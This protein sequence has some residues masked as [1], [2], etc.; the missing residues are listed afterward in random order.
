MKTITM[1]KHV[2]IRLNK[3][4]DDILRLHVRRRGDVRNLIVRAVENTDYLRLEVKSR[5][6]GRTK[7]TEQEYRDTSIMFSLPVFQKLKKCAE[8]KN[9]SLSAL[10]DAIIVKFYLS[11][12]T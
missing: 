8:Q 12:N 3:E 11:D 10:A 9:V 7:L 5:R 6:R 2:L 4:T 1:Q